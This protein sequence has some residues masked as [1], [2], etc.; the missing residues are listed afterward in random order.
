MK[1]TRQ[2]KIEYQQRGASMRAMDRQS[3]RFNDAVDA[4]ELVMTPV[5]EMTSVDPWQPPLLYTENGGRGAL[6]SECGKY[7]Y[8][9]WRLWDDLRPV[10]VWV[11]LNPSTADADVDDT[12]IRKCMGFARAHHFGGIIVVNLFAWRAT[13]P[14][15]LRL[16]AD[17]VGPDNDEH[18]LW[19]CTAPL[20]LAVVAGWGSDRFARERARHVKV[21]IQGG[22]RRDIKCFRRTDAGHPWH[23]LYLP[24]SS[25]L[26]QL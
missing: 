10:M 11:M 25:P 3:Q 24:Y 7:R 26:V 9:L 18:I 5:T 6:L 13:N 23:P 14:R 15:D 2:Q 20:M 19:A 17:P 12:T 1:Q 8:R 21:L 16:V 4:G 22:A